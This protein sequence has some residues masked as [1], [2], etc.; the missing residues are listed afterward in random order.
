MGIHA[1]HNTMVLVNH[2]HNDC[3]DGDHEKGEDCDED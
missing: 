2:H 3:V 1:S